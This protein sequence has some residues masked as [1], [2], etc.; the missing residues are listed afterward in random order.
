MLIA[1]DVSIA[2]I[3]RLEKKFQ[4]PRPS[5]PKCSGKVWGHGFR[6]RYFSGFSDG[7]YIKR[8][9]CHHCKLLIS[10]VPSGYWAHFRSPIQTIYKTLLYR[11]NQKC[12]PKECSRQ[13]GGHW[14]RK[15]ITRFKVVTGISSNNDPVDFLKNEFERG[16]YFLAGPFRKSFIM[17]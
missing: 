3:S 6:L 15:F 16:V 12:W 8:Y 14:L 13:R 2:D 17:N 7:I 4:W 5:C 11:L 9:R 10:L 1:V